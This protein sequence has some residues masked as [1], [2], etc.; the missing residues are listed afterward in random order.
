MARRKVILGH[1]GEV[2]PER[3]P[4]GRI[5]VQGE[6]THRDVSCRRDGI[7]KTRL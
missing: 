3:N 2:A 7:A 5:G 4:E 1:G 6:Q